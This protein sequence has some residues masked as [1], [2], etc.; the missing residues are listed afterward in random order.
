MKGDWNLDIVS[1]VSYFYGHAHRGA[2][3]Y[4]Y[5]NNLNIESPP[6]RGFLGSRIAIGVCDEQGRAF[7][8][9]RNR[10]WIGPEIYMF[11]SEDDPNGG[12]M[13]P[14]SRRFYGTTT[15]EL[16]HASHFN[17]S[18]WHY[19][20]SDDIVKES[21][22]VGVSYYFTRQIYPNTWNWQDMPLDDPSTD[23]DM[24]D[25]GEREYTPFVIDV[26]DNN[27]Q[28][29]VLGNPLLPV[30]RCTEFTLAEVED[31][32]TQRRTLNA[33]RDGL[34]SYR[35]INDNLLDEVTANYTAIQ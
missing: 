12:S 31:Q 3:T 18:H 28:R 35:R 27:N 21:W 10:L 15:H 32:L 1:G 8:R 19:R 22:A 7:Y 13:V 20:N 26:I 24:V 16:A 9:R 17:L 6:E 34:K 33:W 2:Y 29:V 25:W 14:N 23:R 30:D 4:Y 5:D 11:T